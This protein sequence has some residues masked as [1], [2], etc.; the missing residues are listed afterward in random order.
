MGYLQTNQ[1]HG[2]NEVACKLIS[3]FAMIKEGMAFSALGGIAIEEGT[4]E[5]AGTCR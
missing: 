4:Q 2:A 5:S 3:A 1:R